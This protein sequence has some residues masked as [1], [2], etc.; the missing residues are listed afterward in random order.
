MHTDHKEWKNIIAP[1]TVYGATSQ[2]SA[3]VQEAEFGA[4]FHPM[5]YFWVQL[6]AVA[7]YL[8]RSVLYM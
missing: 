8:G 1:E 6:R 7:S 3:L 2:S 5:A 4:S